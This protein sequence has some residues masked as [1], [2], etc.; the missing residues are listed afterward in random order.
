MYVDF[1][2]IADQ[3]FNSIAPKLEVILDNKLSPILLAISNLSSQISS[4][5]SSFS[6]PSSRGLASGFPDTRQGEMFYEE[7]APDAK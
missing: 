2:T 5:A 7:E 1:S 6:V 3:I 4:I